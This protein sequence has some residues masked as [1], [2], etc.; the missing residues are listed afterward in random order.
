MD[1]VG[2][3]GLVSHCCFPSLLFVSGVIP[4]STAAP[5]KYRLSQGLWSQLTQVRVHILCFVMM[6]MG[7]MFEMREIIS[8]YF[9]FDGIEATTKVGVW[10]KK[11]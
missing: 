7:E 8:R 4:L 6:L 1:V 9:W 5:W 11:A 2:K 10:I 3:C